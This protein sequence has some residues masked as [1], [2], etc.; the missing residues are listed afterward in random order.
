MI[1]DW[2][3]AA[4][5]YSKVQENSAYSLF[6]KEFVKSF[7]KNLHKKELLDAGCG[8]GYYSNYFYQQEASVIG[9]DGSFEMIKIAKA[10]YPKINFDVADLQAALPYRDKQ[11]DIIFCNQVLMNLENIQKF[12]T[13]VSRLLK[14]GGDFY[15]S[16][17]H[18]CF[19]LG[20][21][22][23]DKNGKKLCKRINNYI[24]HST[25]I[26][27]FWGTT[28][29]YHRPISFYL[30]LLSENGLVLNKMYEPAISNDG[31]D[32]ATSRIPL[33]LFAKMTKQ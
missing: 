20:D 4:K 28:S 3:N 1:N 31:I 16:I 24:D 7:V 27:D 12:I 22:E 8:D 13:E 29:H 17:V 25:E 33:F 9:C 32:D 10:R 14:S 30:N 15:F 5:I 23:L 19:F 18:P 2:D 21:W 11:F 6:N 26:N